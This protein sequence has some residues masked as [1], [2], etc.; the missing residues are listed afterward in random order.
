MYWD[1][2]G[3]SI[4]RAKTLS[5]HLNHPTGTVSNPQAPASNPGTSETVMPPAAHAPSQVLDYRRR[6][7]PTSTS[8]SSQ[9]I[10]NSQEQIHT[11]AIRNPRFIELCINN[12]IYSKTLG[13]VDISNASSDAGTFDRIANV[14]YEKRNKR[15]VILAKLPNMFGNTLAKCGLQLRFQKPASITFRKVHSYHI[16]N[17]GIG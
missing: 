13:G 16:I 1:I 4:E 9:S 10:Y 17:L 2:K 14:Y 5:Q 15:G 11:Q 6:Y 7:I 8:P 12:G 3:L